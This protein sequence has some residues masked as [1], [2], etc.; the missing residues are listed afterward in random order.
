MVSPERSASAYAAL[1]LGDQLQQLEAVFIC[2]DDRDALCNGP[3]R[4]VRARDR[5]VRSG[6]AG[7]PSQWRAVRTGLSHPPSRWRQ[8]GGHSGARGR[9]LYGGGPGP[10]ENGSKV[11]PAHQRGGAEGWRIVAFVRQ[12][13][14][15]PFGLL[16]YAFG[17]THIRLVDYVLAPFV[18]MLPGTLAYA[19]LGQAGREA[20]S[21]GELPIWKALVT[22][23][24]LAAAAFLPRRV[25]RVHASKR[26]EAARV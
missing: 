14:I 13:P 25:R 20:L 6:R 17:L 2:R 3:C 1:T 24:L 8:G 19:Y 12:V 21:G 23:A 10:A 15:L 18:C 22:L 7:R 26:P 11:G 16:N 4:A 9:T 5:S